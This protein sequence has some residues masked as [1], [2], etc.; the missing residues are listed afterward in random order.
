MLNVMV[1]GGQGVALAVSG[2]SPC[3]VQRLQVV[4]AAVELGLA[5]DADLRQARLLL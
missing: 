2:V 1:I 3:V 4:V 5:A